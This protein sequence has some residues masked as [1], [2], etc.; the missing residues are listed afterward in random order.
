MGFLTE[1]A[2][3]SGVS[4]LRQSHARQMNLSDAGVILLLPGYKRSVFARDADRGKRSGRAERYGGGS[5]AAIVTELGQG[6]ETGA[7]PS[8]QHRPRV[9]QCD[10]GVLAGRDVHGRTPCAA[11]RLEST[12]ENIEFGILRLPDKR[13]RFKVA[14]GCP[15]GV[16][17]A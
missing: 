13:L 1:S 11:V 15:D 8:D 12:I 16:Q 6:D 3:A 5:G 9:T 2:L 10:A 7:V 14:S 17:V 4:S